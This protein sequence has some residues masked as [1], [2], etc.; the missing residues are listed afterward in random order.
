MAIQK[1]KTALTAALVALGLT[2]GTALAAGGGVELIDEHF[3]HEG[4]FGAFDKAAVQ[5][6]YQVFTTVCAGCHGAKY[7][8]FR[9]LGDLGYS[10]DQIK[11][12]ASEYSVTDGPNDDGEMFERAAI[13]SDYFPSPYPNEKAARAANG[14]ALPPDLSLIT[15][16]RPHGTDYVY[17]VLVGYEEPPAD[18]T[19]PDGM[20]F[21]AYFPGHQIAMPQ[22]LYG[23]DVTFQ[24]GTDTSL[25]QIAHD[26]TSF[27]HW[28]AEP[29]LEERKRTGIKAM[30]FLV[31][32]TGIFYAY[33]RR[34]WSDQH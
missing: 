22:P 4:P 34:V 27:L 25:H 18:V 23:D 24:D 9:N 33:K 11:A 30:I 6:G 12:L 7:L 13:A 14:G 29:K 26:V 3:H 17:S 8:A 32:F 1:M 16:A 15:K 20:H 21:N 28:V 2:S 19:I 31:I 10:D 5:R